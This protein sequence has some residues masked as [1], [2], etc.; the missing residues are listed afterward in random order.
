M[1]TLQELHP[2]MKN[3]T[4]LRSSVLEWLKEKDVRIVQYMAGHKRV[5]STE[6]YQAIN[7]EDLRAVE[8]SIRWTNEA[9]FDLW[10]LWRNRWRSSSLW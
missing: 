8:C 10:S 7:L 3:L 1:A 9:F 4:Q 6:R 5:S 2:E